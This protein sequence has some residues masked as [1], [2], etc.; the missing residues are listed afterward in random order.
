VAALTGTSGA[1]VGCRGTRA[2]ARCL[3]GTTAKESAGERIAGAIR[4]EESA[5]LQRR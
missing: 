4:F 5:P 1:V 3:S 2:R